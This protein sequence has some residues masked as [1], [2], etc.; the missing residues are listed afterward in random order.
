MGFQTLV[1]LQGQGPDTPT[2]LEAFLPQEVQN[3]ERKKKTACRGTVHVKPR[4][5]SGLW[6][7]RNM[8]CGRVWFSC[9][10]M[11]IVSMQ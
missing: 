3:S 10:T 11:H 5:I 6:A 9:V 1:I 2:L 4:H 8:E 7:V